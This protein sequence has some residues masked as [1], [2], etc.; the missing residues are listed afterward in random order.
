MH[1]SEYVVVAVGDTTSVPLIGSLPV[2]PPLPVQDVVAGLAGMGVP[3]SK[4]TA[5][6]R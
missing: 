2:H 6:V 3:A 5:A 1:C 4:M